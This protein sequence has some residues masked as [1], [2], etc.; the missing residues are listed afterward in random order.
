MNNH[1]NVKVLLKA[2]DMVVDRDILK[3]N[4]KALFF[5]FTLVPQTGIILL[6]TGL[7]FYT[8]L[9]VPCVLLRF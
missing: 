7:S 1:I 3:N 2:F 6:E 4:H 5:S 9:Y 8:R